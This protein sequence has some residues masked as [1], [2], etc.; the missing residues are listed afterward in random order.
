MIPTPPYIFSFFFPTILGLNSS[1]K[2]GR[3]CFYFPAASLTGTPLWEWRTNPFNS[4]LPHKRPLALKA[5]ARAAPVAPATRFCSLAR[6][7]AVLAGRAE[8]AA[9]FTPRAGARTRRAAGT[10]ECPS[11]MCP[12]PPPPMEVMEGPLNLVSAGSGWEGGR[13]GSAGAAAARAAQTAGRG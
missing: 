1:K 10:G 6:R 7:C 8:A 5:E 11:P 12:Q 9:V 2:Q 13:G 3:R 4:R